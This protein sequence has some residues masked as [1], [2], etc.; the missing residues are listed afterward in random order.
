MCEK[1][2]LSRPEAAHYL[3]I[4]TQTLANRRHDGPA[5]HKLFGAVR[6]AKKDLEA[7]AGQQRVTPIRPLLA[8][9][10]AH[11]LVKCA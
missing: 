5:Y 3:G 2:F 6:Y 9:S 1:E 4:A 11:R 7:W 10:R 8:V